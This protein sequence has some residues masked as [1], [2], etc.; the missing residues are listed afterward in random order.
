MKTKSYKTKR[1]GRKTNKLRQNTVTPEIID[2]D[3]GFMGT[4]G[5]VLKA[6][7]KEKKMERGM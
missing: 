5:K 3:F 6:L 2:K 7:M 4:K 1:K